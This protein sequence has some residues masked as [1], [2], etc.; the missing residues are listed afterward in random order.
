MSGIAGNRFYFIQLTIVQSSGK[1]HFW[2]SAM[3]D[4]AGLI[5]HDRVNRSHS[6]DNI[7]ILKVEFISSICSL[8]A[9]MCERRG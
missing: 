4:C 8:H 9:P 7:G 3:R 2:R 6:F 1:L 5:E